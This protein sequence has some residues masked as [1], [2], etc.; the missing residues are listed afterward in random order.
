MESFYNMHLYL[1]NN[2][3]TTAQLWKFLGQ[4]AHK[5]LP[6]DKLYSF[7]QQAY[8][9]SKTQPAISSFF[10]KI[11]PNNAASI[12]PSTSF[13]HKLR[14]RS[15][16][17]EKERITNESMD[18]VIE[19]PILSSSSSF[20]DIIP[21]SQPS[22]PSRRKIVKSKTGTSAESIIKKLPKTDIGEIFDMLDG[23]G[24]QPNK[25]ESKM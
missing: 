7:I 10:S 13:Q 21:S 19:T 14:T 3:I 15:D 4:F 20:E 25:S 9:D 5:N 8:F 12:T 24:N 1:G 18:F 16:R 17:P 23:N 22:S 2:Q 6:E 11:T